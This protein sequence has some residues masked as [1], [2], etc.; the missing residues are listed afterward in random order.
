MDKSPTATKIAYDYVAVR[1]AQAQ[2]AANRFHSCFPA[3][4][5]SLAKDQ[6]RGYAIVVID[7][8]DATPE[9]V[10]FF[11]GIRPAT[12]AIAL[13]C[14]LPAGYEF[15]D[16]ADPAA[17]AAPVSVM[18]TLQEVEDALILRHP[19]LAIQRVSQERATLALT[20]WL[21]PSTRDHDL[22]ALRADLT[23]F[24]LFE[25][26]VSFRFDV[27]PPTVDT[28]VNLQ[29]NPFQIA[30]AG[31]RHP[32]IQALRHIREDDERWH[33]QLEVAA[34]GDIRPETI[35][36][37]PPGLRS[38]F[39]PSA[40]LSALPD[41]RNYLL[42]YEEVILEVPLEERYAEARAIHRLDD[43]EIASAAGRGRL[44]LLVTQ[45]EER[46]PLRLLEIVTERSPSSLIGRRAG[47]VYAMAMLSKRMGDFR[48][49]WPDAEKLA[50]PLASALQ[51]RLRID[52][53]AIERLL[54]EPIAT[55]HEALTRLA[56]RD[57]KALPTYIGEDA[58]AVVKGA[59]R[60]DNTID[61]TLEFI[62]ANLQMAI[63]N[64]FGA[65]LAVSDRQAYLHLPCH[66]LGAVH[67]AS[68]RE[69][70]SAVS[71]SHTSQGMFINPATPIFEFSE[72]RPMEKLLE[73]VTAQDAAIANSILCDLASLPAEDRQA[74]V[75]AIMDVVAEFGGKPSNLVI[76]DGMLAQY[77][78]IIA[79]VI[80][81][82][83]WVGPVLGAAQIVDDLAGWFASAERLKRLS[84]DVPRSRRQVELLRRMRPVA[85]L[86]EKCSGT[87]HP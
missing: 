68:S 24:G 16:L 84:D 34:R 31:R 33:S 44:R 62:V 25:T 49:R 30:R 79:Q 66:M 75:V 69:M 46:L 47:A 17:F 86:S 8:A 64:I 21:D 55:Y 2:W 54:L 61:P 1:A 51:P 37:R 27:A 39:I 15:I 36:P 56:G 18:M 45:P 4:R 43:G 60:V 20:V 29:P 48:A 83:P 63:A 11:D 78:R 57:I 10:E 14:R 71:T 28:K 19:L 32:R 52:Q 58:W 38:I 6:G 76:G 12:A 7:P 26:G 3:S 59:I 65:E 23:G 40:T 74:R 82:I 41:I 80:G 53:A 9:R 81:F 5:F 73:L 42:T 85:W 13:V 77:A 35:I 22:T 67:A 50:R 87:R 72:L 70:H